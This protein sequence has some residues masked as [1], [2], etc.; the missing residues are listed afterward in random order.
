MDWSLC[1]LYRKLSNGSLHVIGRSPMSPNTGG[2]ANSGRRWSYSK[3]ERVVGVNHGP[4]F[5]A[6]KQVLG[7]FRDQFIADVDANTVVWE[8]LYKNIIP[9]G[10]QERISRTDEPKQQNEIL[11]DCLQRTCT[12]EALME[13]C[14]IIVSVRGHPKM[15]E[16][17]EAMKRRLHT[18]KC[19]LVCRRE[20]T[21]SHSLHYRLSC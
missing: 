3:H 10:V 6:A 8:L 18:G 19:V 21:R 7:D 5:H 17:G 9:R 11:H 4:P 13:V 15:R 2:P 16:L 14:D 1:G 20:M 12:K